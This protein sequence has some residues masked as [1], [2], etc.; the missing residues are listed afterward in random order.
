VIDLQGSH[1]L[2]V[3]DSADKVSIR[4]VTLGDT[5]GSQWIVT[6]GVRPGERV[7]VEGIQK[8]RPGMQVSPKP[9]E[10]K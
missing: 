1:Q 2:A 9:Y 6:S 7:V 4:T 3:V 10:T 5:V 8:V